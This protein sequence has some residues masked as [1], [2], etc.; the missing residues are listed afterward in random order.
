[1]KKG[2]QCLFEKE[3][4]DGTTLKFNT[5]ESDVIRPGTRMYQLALVNKGLT[6]QFPTNYEDFTQK[7]IQIMYDSIQSKKDFDKIRTR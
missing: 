7:Q 4:T 1:M 5:W 2:I 6:I 3:L